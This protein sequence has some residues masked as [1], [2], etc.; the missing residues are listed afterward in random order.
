[1][2]SNDVL[3]WQDGDKDKL[4]VLL[5]GNGGPA[6]QTLDNFAELLACAAKQ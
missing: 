6:V 1:M 4:V 3:E 5:S 2:A